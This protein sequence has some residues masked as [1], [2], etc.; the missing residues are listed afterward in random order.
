[1]PNP[2]RNECF[3]RLAEGREQSS[4]P[5]PSAPTVMLDDFI[6]MENFL[7]QTEEPQPPH[8]SRMKSYVTEGSTT[9]PI[10]PALTGRPDSPRA[11]SFLSL[12]SLTDD[13]KFIRCTSSPRST[14]Y[15][16]SGSL[17][18]LNDVSVSAFSMAKES[19]PVL[20]PSPT[21]NFKAAKQRVH[22]YDALRFEYKKPEGE[23]DIRE[24]LERKPL[25]WSIVGQMEA[26]KRWRDQVLQDMVKKQQG[27]QQDFEVRKRRLLS[28]F[29]KSVKGI[30]LED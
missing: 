7:C 15:N 23:I 18:S 1:M 27:W 3:L 12:Y 26:N 21:T 6:P 10:S 8:P 30:S 11:G 9:P 2:V 5:P 29:K 4:T 16:A 14:I 20:S 24:A 22:R 19:K 25:R 13:D 17:S 28:P